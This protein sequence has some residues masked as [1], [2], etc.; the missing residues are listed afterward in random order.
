MKTLITFIMILIIPIG[1]AGHFPV[2]LYSLVVERESNTKQFLRMNG[3]N[4]LAYY[5]VYYLMFMLMSIFASTFYLFCCWIFIDLKVI[6]Q[7]NLM[8]IAI[9]FLLWAHS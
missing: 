1:V 7:T 8:L 5:G 3:M 9:T 2:F 6:M 4:I